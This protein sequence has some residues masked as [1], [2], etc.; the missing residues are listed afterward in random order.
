MASP[1]TPVL[2]VALPSPMWVRVYVSERDLGRIRPGQHATV[3]TDTYPGRIYHGWVGY[4]SPTAEFTPKSVQTADLRTSLVYQLRVYVCDGRGELRLGMPAT[5]RIDLRRRGTA[6]GCRGVGA[7]TAGGV[8][9][10]A[11]P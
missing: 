10:G 7:R 3:T 4:L 8:S 9:A 5:V 6:P 2:T 1:G 11:R